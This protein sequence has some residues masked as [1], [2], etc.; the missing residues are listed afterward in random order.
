M[1]SA[2]FAKTEY[3]P[4]GCEPG[5]YAAQSEFDIQPSLPGCTNGCQPLWYTNGETAAIQVRPQIIIKQDG[6]VITNSTRDV[7]VGQQINLT[8]EVRSGRTA[9][10]NPQWAVLGNRIANYTA[11]SDAGTVT[12]LEGL[13]D[14]ALSFYWVDEGDNRQVTYSV[15][16]RNR[17]YSGRATFNVKRPTVDVTTSTG[18]VTVRTLS[19]SERIYELT[20]GTPGI[21]FTRTNLTIPSGFTGD[22]VWVQLVNASRVRRRSDGT[23]DVSEGTG[24]DSRFPYSSSDPNAIETADSPGLRL[25]LEYDYATVN[26]SFQTWLMFKPSGTN[27][28]YVPLRRVNWSWAGAAERPGTLNWTLVPGSAS[29]TQ[30]PPDADSTTHPTWTRR[31]LLN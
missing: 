18:T 12:P 10:T 22:T 26:D 30:N 11:S 7:I 9:T 28:I 17:S 2:F 29:N 1:P 13:T 23:N 27:S 24:L 20:Y 6:Q 5:P 16:A 8:A 21:R 31:V 4:G 3:T 19:F 14:T 25:T 15:T